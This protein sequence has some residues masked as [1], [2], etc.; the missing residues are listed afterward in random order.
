MKKIMV[1]FGGMLAAMAILITTINVNSTCIC[2]AYQPELPEEAFKL[3][4]LKDE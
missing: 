3:R 2:F 4:K 1:K